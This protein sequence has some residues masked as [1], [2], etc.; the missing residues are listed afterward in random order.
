M[1]LDKTEWVVLTGF[2]AGLGLGVALCL[3]GWFGGAPS[4][5]PLPGPSPLLGFYDLGNDDGYSSW[6]PRGNYLS[7]PPW[8]RH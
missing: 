1:A 6:R 4:L 7:L 5:T 3:K 2:A 8:P